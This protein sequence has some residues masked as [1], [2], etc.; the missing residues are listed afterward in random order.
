MMLVY[1]LYSFIEYIRFVSLKLYFLLYLMGEPE[2]KA[3]STLAYNLT[4]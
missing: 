4:I 2:D 3:R 1:N